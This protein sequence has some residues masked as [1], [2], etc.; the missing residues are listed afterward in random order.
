MEVPTIVNFLEGEVE[1]TVVY[2]LE[3]IVAILV[4]FDAVASGAEG[5]VLEIDYDW[6]L[7]NCE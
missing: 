4:Q 6:I 5:D 2:D 7:G 1:K 3:W